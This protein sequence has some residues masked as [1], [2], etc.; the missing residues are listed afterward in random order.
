MLTK[1]ERQVMHKACMIMVMITT[2]MAMEAAASRPIL[3]PLPS[4]PTSLHLRPV[5]QQAGNNPIQHTLKEDDN[6]LLTLLA[7]QHR[8]EDNLNQDKI[9][10]ED[11]G[12]WNPTPKFGGGDY[13]PIPH[14]KV[15]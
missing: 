14:G 6:N 4:P 5:E 13:A 12:F 2:A 7:E 11:Y 15:S 9:E 8:K 1:I 10:E 3:S